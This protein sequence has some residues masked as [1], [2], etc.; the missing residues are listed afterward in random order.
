MEE[1]ES[2]LIAINEEDDFDN[3]EDVDMVDAEEGEIME[4]NSQESGKGQ[5]SVGDVG[6]SKEGSLDKMPEN[7]KPSKKKKNKKKKKRKNRPLPKAM[8]INR[9]VIDTCRRLKEKKSYMVYAA[10]GCLG[11][12]AL[13]DLI[14]EVEAIQSCGGQ[15]TADG[16][17]KRTGG[18]VLW[19]I[20]KARQPASYREIMKK[21]REFEK[22]FRHPIA[23]QQ[24]GQNKEG[25][26]EGSLC[27][28]PDEAPAS[29]LNAMPVAEQEESKRE[30]RKSVHERIRMPVSYDDLFVEGHSNASQTHSSA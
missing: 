22:Q 29:E 25:S 12:S 1:E 20:I 4:H 11:V 15:V 7:G 9:F 26:S 19:N 16:S 5:S 27:V 18:G 14:N 6:D 2:V 28:S 3:I 17:R 24:L 30:E 23:R 10:V 13:S 21:T 8:D